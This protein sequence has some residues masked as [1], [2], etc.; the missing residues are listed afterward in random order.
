VKYN[1]YV[2]E[3]SNG[4]E[5]GHSPNVKRFVIPLYE[6]FITL[7]NLCKEAVLGLL[8]LCL[9][10]LT[11]HSHSHLNPIPSNEAPHALV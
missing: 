3:L 5:R 2:V 7:Y 11:E 8:G 6:L 1:L 4:N 10:F 9:S